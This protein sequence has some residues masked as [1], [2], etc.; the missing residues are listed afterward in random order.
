MQAV[1]FLPAAAFMG[2]SPPVDVMA[3]QHFHTFFLYEDPPPH[4]H[5]TPAGC[6][7]PTEL[8]QKGLFALPFMARALERQRQAVRQDAAELMKELEEQEEQEVGRGVC[9]RVLG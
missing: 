7:E 2:A 9:V 3:D 8:P 1:A 6:S 4:T 5:T